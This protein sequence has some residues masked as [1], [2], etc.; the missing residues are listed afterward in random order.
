MPA[1]L[2][3]YIPG[4]PWRKGAVYA[5]AVWL[6]NAFIVLP[7]IGEGIAGHRY[8]TFAGM[9][10]FAFA[11]TVFFLLLAVLYERLHKSD[12]VRLS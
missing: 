12:Q 3:P 5:A 9:A 7:W 4:S 10:Y 6:A 11:H 8:L 2:E 1:V